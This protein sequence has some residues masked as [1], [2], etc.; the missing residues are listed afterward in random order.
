M[1]NKKARDA[2]G[3]WQKGHCP[4]PKGRPRKEVGPKDSDILHFKNGLIKLTINDKEQL[5][6]RHE[7]LVHMMFA[8][9]M[10]G[11]SVLITR[12][13]YELFEGADQ[14][15]ANAFATLDLMRKDYTRFPNKKLL[16]AV[17]LAIEIKRLEGLLTM[18][19]PDTGRDRRRARPE[20][21]AR[22][23]TPTADATAEAATWRAEVRARR[24]A[25][26][27]AEQAAAQKAASDAAASSSADALSQNIPTDIQLPAE[28]KKD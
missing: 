2:S 23:P 10:K 14:T 20:P 5:V 12:K 24:L 18:G 11:G 17:E 16:P 6:T 3:R 13:L 9:A 19:E 27:Q 26:E 8:K 4:N 15:I 28:T 1:R 22:A 21:P 25:R 7:A